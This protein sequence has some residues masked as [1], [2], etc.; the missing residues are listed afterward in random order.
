MLLRHLENRRLQAEKA[1]EEEVITA[2]KLDP[3][4]VRMFRNVFI[5]CAP[6]NEDSGPN[7]CKAKVDSAGIRRLLSIKFRIVRTE[8][9]KAQ[10]DRAMQCVKQDDHSRPPSRTSSR[11]SS[12]RN[13]SNSRGTTNQAVSD[14]N[15]TARDTV[16]SRTTLKQPEKP[17]VH[18]EEEH[19]FNFAQFLEIL[20]MLDDSGS[21]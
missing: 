8:K 19:H 2:R 1:H 15:T 11:P 21:F 20:G 18:E 13:A 16:A 4:S 10:L 5:S 14:R 12:A 3:D 9:Q 6:P 7:G 17:M